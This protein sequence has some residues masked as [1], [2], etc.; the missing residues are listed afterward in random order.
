MARLPP[1][2]WIRRAKWTYPAG[3]VN[4]RAATEECMRRFLVFV[5]VSVCL[6]SG[7]AAIA[8]SVQLR[9]KHA[10]GQIDRYK[11]L[12]EVNVVVPNMP[13]LPCGPLNMKMGFVWTQK[14]LGILP[15][16]SAKVRFT[17]QDM[18]LVASERTLEFTKNHLNDMAWTA[19]IDREGNVTKVQRAGGAGVHTGKQNEVGDGL[20]LLI[21]GCF[22]RESMEVGDCWDANYPMPW[23]S[24]EIRTVSR[25]DAAAV[26]RGK[27]VVSKITQSTSGQLDISKVLV[28]LA[29]LSPKFAAR[30][31]DMLKDFSQIKGA[32]SV[33]GSSTLYF[34]PEQGRIVQ[35]DGVCNMA[36]RMTMPQSM[37]AQGAPSEVIAN[38]DVRAQMVRL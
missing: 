36:M 20:W 31:R 13:Q 38:M 24:G 18:K 4:P 5:I 21:G 16:G 11:I 12:M 7:D 14:V 9:F 32:V 3:S 2:L 34:A 26:T 23:K 30:D 6:L 22:P 28:G 19:I 25:L 1:R 37:I 15:D 29:Q 10:A 8:K 17:Y 35:A 27:F 33:N